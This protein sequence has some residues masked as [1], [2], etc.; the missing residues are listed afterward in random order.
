MGAIYLCEDLVD[1]DD[2][3]AKKNHYGSLLV[4]DWGKMCILKNSERTRDLLLCS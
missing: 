3:M 1:F 4:N 2:V